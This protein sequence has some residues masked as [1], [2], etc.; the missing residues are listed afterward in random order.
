MSLVIMF[1]CLWTFTCQARLALLSAL[2]WLP[3]HTSRSR[4]NTL[5]MTLTAVRWNDANCFPLNILKRLWLGSCDVGIK[6]LFKIT[7]SNDLFYSYISMWGFA[8][9]VW[10][11]IISEL[12]HNN[13]LLQNTS[14]QKVTT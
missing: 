11:F 6:L 9:V 2:P 5:N 4:R 14:Q 1:H 3:R 12:I 13:M 10:K 7:N 8:V